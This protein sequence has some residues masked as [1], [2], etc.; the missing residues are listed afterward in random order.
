MTARSARITVVTSGH[1]ST[2]PRMVKSADALAAAG[3]DVS[4]VATCHEP[5][6]AETDRDVRSRR[7]WPVRGDRLSPRHRRSDLLV[8][9]RAVSR[10]ARRVPRLGPE[11]APLPIVARAFGRVHAAHRRRHLGRAGRSHLRRHDRRPRGDR[12]GGAPAPDAV[13]T[14]PRG[15]PQR[16]RRAVPRR[17]LSTRSP[18]RIERAVLGDAAFLTTSSEA[19]AAAYREQYGVAPVS[20]PQHLSAAGAA[21]RFLARRSGDAAALLVQ[22]DDWSGPRPRR[23]GDGARAAPACR[24]SW[25]CAAAP[26]DG[27]LDALRTPGGGARAARRGCPSAAGAARRDGGSRARLRRRPRAR[28]R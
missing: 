1:L 13:R 6:A 24:R 10:R 5:W 27:Y 11:R 16:E 12:R 7:T 3:Y 19:I 2:C 20:R 25:R 9:G 23:R 17:R 18:T 4:V 21:A 26:Q 28:A 8:D 14:G 15:F 22:P